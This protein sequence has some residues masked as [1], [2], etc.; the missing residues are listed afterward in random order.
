MW[1]YTSEQG[2]EI[3]SR[4]PSLQLKC[5]CNTF[6]M[7]MFWNKGYRGQQLVDLNQCHLWLQ[8]TMVADITDGHGM[9]LLTIILAGNKAHLSPLSKQTPPTATQW[10]FLV[11]GSQR[12]PYPY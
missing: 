5:D 2:W 4:L 3:V 6:L 9:H 10:I 12:V 8:V 7:E 11:N 1:Q